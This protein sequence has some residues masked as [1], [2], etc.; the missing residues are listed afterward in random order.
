[1]R[2]GVHS[3]PCLY[4]LLEAHA[5]EVKRERVYIQTTN[6]RC[7]HTRACTYICTS[8]LLYPVLDNSKSARI[9]VVS[10]TVTRD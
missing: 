1:M 4:L 7:T 6:Q 2:V 9:I 10:F 3:V 8:G 5:S